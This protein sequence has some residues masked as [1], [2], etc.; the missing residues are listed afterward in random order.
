[1]RT[2]WVF[3]GGTCFNFITT[4]LMEYDCKDDVFS[5]VPSSSTS[6]NDEILKILTAISSQMVVGQHDLHQQL[7]SSNMYLKTELQK[8][9]VE[10]EKFKQE[11]RTELMNTVPPIAPSVF[12][13]NNDYNII[14]HGRF[15]SVFITW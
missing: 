13:F 10:N 12:F 9:R 1:M 3:A 2:S 14:F 15:L 5:S 8:V 11:M 6:S 4:F 7:V